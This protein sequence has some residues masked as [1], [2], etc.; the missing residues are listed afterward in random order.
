M[1]LTSQQLYDLHNPSYAASRILTVP[2]SD[3]GWNRIDEIMDCIP[4][5]T[6][7]QLI[8]KALVI[9]WHAD[10]KEFA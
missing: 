9:A 8:E 3:D 5:L 6:L 1:I 7:A 10:D 2:L 4:G